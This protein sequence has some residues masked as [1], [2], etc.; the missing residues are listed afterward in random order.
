MISLSIFV[1][2]NLKRM[3]KT[4]L[5]ASL[6]MLT[7]GFNSCGSEDS[8]TDEHQ[9]ET[10]N[11]TTTEN[12]EIAALDAN[13]V[14][15]LDNTESENVYVAPPKAAKGTKVL[16]KTSMGDV[17]VLLYDE[18]PGHRDNFVKLVKEKFYND[19]LFHR[20]IKDF[21]IQTGDP[22]SVGA[23]QGVNLGAGGPGYTLPAE[24]IPGL[25]H[26]KGALSAARQGDQTNPLKASSG[27]QFYIVT[28][29]VTPRAQLDQMAAQ[30]NKQAQDQAVG[31]FLEDP[32]NAAYMEQYKAFQ[33]MYQTQD[34]AKM[35]EAQKGFET[36]IAE[37]T[38]L[39]TA[40]LELPGY[41]E[42]QKKVYETIGGTPFLDNNYTVFGEVIEGLDIVDKIGLVATAPGDRPVEDVKIISMEIVKK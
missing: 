29:K 13:E 14:K 40:N 42:E 11:N 19:I 21:M 27:S 22:V 26:K 35:A 1:V 9:E 34:Q 24:I 15:A 30:Q 6:F 38:P 3:K 37:I 5:L 8:K 18:T 28:G 4:I 17:K 25:F 32:K 33:A 23:A 39:A 31:A 41:T 2:Q 20:V 10:S 7:L 12:T 16:I 36:L